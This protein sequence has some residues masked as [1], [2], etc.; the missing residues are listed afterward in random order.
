MFKKVQIFQFQEP[1]RTHPQQPGTHSRGS[2]GIPPGDVC[3][4]RINHLSNDKIGCLF[5]R[6]V[7]EG[8]G[9]EKQE[10]GDAHAFQNA[11]PGRFLQGSLQYLHYLLPFRA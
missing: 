9:I 7:R 1:L 6:R 5:P 3:H 4:W 11:H 8:S 2:V 10:T